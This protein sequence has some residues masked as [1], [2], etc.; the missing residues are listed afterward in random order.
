MDLAADPL[1]QC[2]QV[3]KNWFYAGIYAYGK[4]EKR[5][6]IV[7]GRARRT[8][9]HYKPAGTWEVMIRG[10]HEDYIG[11]DEYERNQKQ[12]ALNAFGRKDGA[13]SGRGGEALLTGLLTCARCG[14][15]LSVSRA[16]AVNTKP[17]QLP[18]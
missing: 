15:R 6:A 16:G 9:G 4:S 17:W 14:H 5:T 13:K 7:D 2:D 1:S 18:G 3:L 10:H 11:W 8:Y 12:L